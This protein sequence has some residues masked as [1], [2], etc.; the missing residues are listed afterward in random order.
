MN[1]VD[2]MGELVKKLR[3]AYDAADSAADECEK[4]GQLLAAAAARDARDRIWAVLEPLDD[5]S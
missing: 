2:S 3:A 1:A 5:E 4:A